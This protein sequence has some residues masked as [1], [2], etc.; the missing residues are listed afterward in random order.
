MRAYKVNF[1]NTGNNSDMGYEFGDALTGDFL[2]ERG[3]STAEELAAIETGTILVKEASGLTNGWE[4][5]SHMTI[6]AYESESYT[7]NCC[8]TEQPGDGLYDICSQCGWENVPDEISNPDTYG[9]PNH[10]SLNEGMANYEKYGWHTQ[11]GW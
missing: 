5:Y 1:H 11:R 8:K 2:I 7:C 6:E 3:F 9:G 4:M 10:M